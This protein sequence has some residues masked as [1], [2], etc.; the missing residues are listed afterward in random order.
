MTRL[1]VYTEDFRFYYKILNLSKEW[2]IPCVSLESTDNI[3][4]DIPV[5]VSSSNDDEIHYTQIREFDVLRAMRRSVPYILSSEKIHNMFIGIDPGPKPGI[6]VLADRVLIEAYELA[7]VWDVEATAR[8]MIE[9]YITDSVTIRIGNGDRP[10]REKIMKQVYNLN[11][12]V[13]I[14]DENGTSMPHRTHDNILS[15][16]RIANIEYFKK[17]KVIHTYNKR[18]NQIEKEFVTIK[19]YI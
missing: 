10:N 14:V 13:C 7:N 17:E 2:Q 15:A 5:V 16:A 11:T 9:D 1:G 6:A 4:E 8:S 12:P 3:P 18:K 19:N